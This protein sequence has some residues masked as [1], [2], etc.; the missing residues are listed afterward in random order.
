MHRLLYIGIQALVGPI[1][2]IAASVGILVASSVQSIDDWLLSPTVY[3]ALL[4]TALR[5][6]AR[7]AFGE[8]IK[9][10]WWNAAIRGNNKL[11]GSVRLTNTNT[12]KKAS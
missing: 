1:S 2:C 3:L 12:R 7:V 11:T 4:K 6:L 5:I 8:G 10:A 9:I